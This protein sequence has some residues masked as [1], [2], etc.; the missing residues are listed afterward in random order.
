MSL[1][2]YSFL[3]GALAMRILTNPARNNH[4]YPHVGAI[5][6]L[7]L[8][9]GAGSS[10]LSSCATQPDTETYS[11]EERIEDLE[12]Q[13][14]MLQ[15]ELERSQE[16]QH[17]TDMQENGCIE[18]AEL[19]EKMMHGEFVE[20]SRQGLLCLAL[21]HDALENSACKRLSTA[22]EVALCNVEPHQGCTAIWR[23]VVHFGNRL[24][25]PAF[26][27]DR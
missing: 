9:V 27:R 23:E 5:T 22:C 11:I 3:M 26:S 21:A 16:P 13:V 6:F 12:W 17:L 18:G 7:V 2:L 25:V 20:G 19:Y 14:I 4:R 10:L 15:A 24:K 1:A 8:A